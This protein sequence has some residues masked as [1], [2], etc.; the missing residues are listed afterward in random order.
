MTAIKGMAACVLAWT[1]LG[2]LVHAAP[3]SWYGSSP[4]MPAWFANQARSNGSFYAPPNSPASNVVPASLSLWWNANG[5]N[6]GTTIN[7]ATVSSAP[8]ATVVATPAVATAIAPVA[9]QAVAPVSNAAPVS[10][11]INFGSGPYPTASDL[12]AGTPQAWYNSPSVAQAFGG[13]PTASQQSGFVQS[14]LADIQHTFQISGMNISLTSDP[15]TPAL[16][17]LSVVSGAWYPSNTGAIGITQVGGNGFGFI[18]K[19]SYATTPD[20]LAWAVAHNVSHELMH[21]LGVATHPDTTGT[22]LDCSTATWQMLTDPNTKFSPEAVQMMLSASGG[23]AGLNSA[24]GAELLH[25]P[26]Y[27]AS[28]NCPFCQSVRKLGLAIDGAQLLEQPVP[29]PATIALW[30]VGGLAGAIALRR[31]SA[32][33][34]A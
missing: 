5:Y 3:V 12:T 14:V 13:T 6:P 27:S 26:G 17:T 25:L 31:R 20:Q 15:G 8:A 33:R 7:S 16:H 23:A 34:A 19:L 32:R 11:F 4:N 28:C 18:D 10:A 1:A 21:A 22:Y 24:L 30:S 2:T 9:A 29:E